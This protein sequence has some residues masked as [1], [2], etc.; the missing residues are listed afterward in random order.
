MEN[1]EISAKTVEEAIQLALA[2]LSVSREE[3]EITV[4]KEGRSGLWGLGSEEARVRVRPRVGSAP[5]GEDVAQ[6]AKE[7]LEKLLAL[8]G[9][10]ASV[11]AKVEPSVEGEDFTAA[12][13]D[14]EGED[15][16]ILIGRRGQTLAALQHI[17]RLLV[18][19][20]LNTA[21]LITIDV[22]D[23]KKRRYEALKNLALRMAEQVKAKKTPFT[24]EP[25]PPYERRIIHLALVDHPDVITYS[26]GE[27]EARKVVIAPKEKPYNTRRLPHR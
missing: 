27:G 2:R 18:T 11:E 3:V 6:T 7:V 16:G 1:L 8:M 22:E 12:T 24:M 4:L 13:L 17:V 15:L 19:H 14:I 21:A 23:Y 10:S 9:L 5:K 26:V 25:M 20:Q